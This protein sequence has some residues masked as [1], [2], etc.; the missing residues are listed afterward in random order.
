MLNNKKINGIVSNPYIL[1]SPT[2][3]VNY[4]YLAY[5]YWAGSNHID[6]ELPKLIEQDLPSGS[7]IWINDQNNQK[8]VLCHDIQKRFDTYNTVYINNS[9]P[10][11]DELTQW[12]ETYKPLKYDRCNFVSL[13]QLHDAMISSGVNM[14]HHVEKVIDNVFD[15]FPPIPH[16]WGRIVPHRD[17]CD[18][19]ICVKKLS[20]DI[21]CNCSKCHSKR[22]EWFNKACDMGL[23][24]G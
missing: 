22:T 2:Y 3:E 23:T 13:S 14:E 19:C 12:I 20:K 1:N 11:C 24:H 10:L 21:G 5:T 15:K 17:N 18:C 16:K 4:G 8:A 7:T 9:T 6:T